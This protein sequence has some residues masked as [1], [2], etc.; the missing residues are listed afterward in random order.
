ME[1]E[2][3][4]GAILNKEDFLTLFEVIKKVTQNEELLCWF[5]TIDKILS[6]SKFSADLVYRIIER[7]K[8]KLYQNDICRN[9][10][11]YKIMNF[12][13]IVINT[14]KY[15]KENAG[16]FKNIELKTRSKV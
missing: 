11:T 2:K 10:D 16:M 1:N 8:H 4:I 6:K 3:A 12:I 5:A 15:L 13:P 14:I 7:D 9:M